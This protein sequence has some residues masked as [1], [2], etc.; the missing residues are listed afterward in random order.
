MRNLKYYLLKSLVISA[1]FSAYSQI[2]SLEI[3]GVIRLTESGILSPA[4]G[5][6]R[7]IGG[8]LE[9]WNG[10]NWL[11]LTGKEIIRDIDNNSYA[12]VKIG[13]QI[14]MAENL[15]V[16]HFNDGTPVDLV[17]KNVIWSIHTDPAYTW[18]EN[19]PSDYGAMYNH[20][21]VSSS[22][23]I[24]PVGWHVPTNIEWKTT[25]SYLGGEAVA[26][27]KLRRSGLE[28]WTA[29]NFLATNESGFDGL[30]GGFRESNGSFFDAT[31][32]GYWWT[33]SFS[34]DG[35]PISFFTVNLGGVL[36]SDASHSP[37]TGLSI[38]CVKN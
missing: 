27:G 33:S 19:S 21:T 8:D 25:A 23:N 29:P 1:I 36:L 34:L 3:Q 24:C 18:Y 31:I 15:R 17:T 11:S 4:P 12:V 16:T 35:Y 38:R 26:G 22:L 5:T 13:D 9:G 6:I 14:W 10:T 20:L 32:G 37:N 2:E 7:W 30:P 28:Y